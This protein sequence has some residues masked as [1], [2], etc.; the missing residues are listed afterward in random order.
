[1]DGYDWGQSAGGK[2][3]TVAYYM[4]SEWAGAWEPEADA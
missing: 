4:L 3:S 1:M 2:G